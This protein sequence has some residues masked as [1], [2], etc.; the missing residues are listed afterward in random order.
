MTDKRFEG[1]VA[2]V[3]GAS[4]GLGHAVA[5]QLGAEGAHV[6]AL[7]RTVGGLEE[8]D[9]AIKAAG[10][11]ATLVPLDLTDDPAL[12]RL[13]A[14]IF[15]RWGRLDFW[16]HTAVHAAPL[17][18]ADHVA[19]KDLDRCLAVNARAPQ[20]L[21]RVLDPLLRAAPAGRA[22]LLDDAPA[23]EK[24]H[25][26][27]AAS[28]AAARAF[29]LSWAAE[30]AHSSVKVWLARPPA[31]PTALRRRMRPGESDEGLAQPRDV[32]TTLI[33]AIAADQAKPGEIVTL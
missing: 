3:T 21:M 15:E 2:L 6:L 32:A 25:G 24:F 26:L 30:K 10:G 23:G 5:E 31:M 22:V 9:D 4:R 17:S 12:E 28:K 13:G 19:E 8:L 20:R 11:A 1:R 18:P 16:V 33:D 29:A 14:A 7:A 27:Y